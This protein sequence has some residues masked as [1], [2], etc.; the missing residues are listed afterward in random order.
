MDKLSTQRV[1][2]Q[3]ISRH[4]PVQHC[5][6]KR[7]LEM[8]LSKGLTKSAY[9]GIADQ[10]PLPEPDIICILHEPVL[11]GLLASLALLP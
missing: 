7:L 6:F 2:L 4:K 9:E 11:L 8:Y 5:S 10:H 1:S 3:I